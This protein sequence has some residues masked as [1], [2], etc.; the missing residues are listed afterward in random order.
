MRLPAP[1][2][3]EFGE[4]VIPL[5]NIVFLLL[6]FFML[7]GTFTTPDP[8]DVDPPESRA[9]QEADDGEGVLLLGADGQLAFEGEEL[10]GDDA[11]IRV[12]EQR[13]EEEPEFELRLKADGAVGSSRLLDLMDRLRDA[14][15]ERLLLLTTEGGD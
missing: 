5:I 9:G 3:R 7:A 13:L 2:R 14:G 15:L 10:E 12:L 11:L 4:P 1:N 6:I 8:F